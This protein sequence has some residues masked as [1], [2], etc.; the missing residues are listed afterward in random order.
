MGIREGGTASEISHWNQAESEKQSNPGFVGVNV[1]IPSR[2]WSKRVGGL[3]SL[4]LYSNQENLFPK[5]KDETSVG[6]REAE[7]QT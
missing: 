7:V 6:F 5:K 3:L 1:I 2:T 4:T